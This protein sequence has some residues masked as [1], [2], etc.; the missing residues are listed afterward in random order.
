MVVIDWGNSKLGVEPNN[1]TQYVY[2]L[3]RGAEI[4]YSL[5]TI[6]GLPPATGSLALPDDSGLIPGLTPLPRE[7]Y[8][9]CGWAPRTPIDRARISQTAQSLYEISKKWLIQFSN[10][11][12]YQTRNSKKRNFFPLLLSL[13]TVFV[14]LGYLLISS[15]F[16]NTMVIEASTATN[17][18]LTETQIL[19]P[20]NNNTELLSTSTQEIVPTEMSK[21]PTDTLTS[22]V[23]PSPYFYTDVVSLFDNKVTSSSFPVRLCWRQAILP[24]N[25]RERESFFRLNDYD[26]WGFFIGGEKSSDETVQASLHNCLTRPVDAMALNAYVTHLEPQR[27]N[28]E[29]GEFGVFLVGQGGFRRDYTLWID[30]ERR[31][32]LRILEDEKIIED[33]LV[34]IVGLSN[35]Q[36]DGE[37]PNDYYKF[38]LQMF[39]EIDNQGMDI[40]YLREQLP[41]YQPVQASDIRQNQMVRIDYA[42][43]PTLGSVQEIGLVG[44]GGHT[45]VIIWPLAFF[46]K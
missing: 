45:E 38:P 33:N 36:R 37:P 41:P 21:V 2:D 27:E 30:M 22:I 13:I 15:N 43:R 11:D 9:L 7:F 25:I 19:I 16:L 12:P 4:I 42:L 31:M 1:K 18:T 23:I 3:A 5:V 10:A 29:G 6:R 28:A 44:R 24:S 14:V 32:R 8:K 35:F 39:L 46:G 17:I 34:S 20:T 40:L 26:W